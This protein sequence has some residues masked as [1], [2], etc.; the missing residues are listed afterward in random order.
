MSEQKTV[1]DFFFSIPL[2]T[3]I[4]QVAS[5]ATRW[6]RHLPD[7]G[8]RRTAI[9]RNLMA[10]VR[11]A[12]LGSAVVDLA[13]AGILATR[14]PWLHWPLLVAGCWMMAAAFV[15]SPDDRAADDACVEAALRRATMAR[16]SSWVGVAMLLGMIPLDVSWSQLLVGGS[17]LA[18]CAGVR[19]VA[20]DT[21]VDVIET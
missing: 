10:K 18:V 19:R 6:P 3:G 17:F 15:L 14:V 7:G 2:V 16:R 21:A 1:L 9:T 13:A 12:F 11:K 4:A 20:V 5:A 8:V